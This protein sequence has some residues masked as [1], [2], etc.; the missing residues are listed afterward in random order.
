MERDFSII[1]SPLGADQLGELVV[2]DDLAEYLDE[3]EARTGVRPYSP[4]DPRRT[5]DATATTR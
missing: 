1:D 5:S 2:G 4:D 3:I